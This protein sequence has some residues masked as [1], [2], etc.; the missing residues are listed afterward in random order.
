M[1]LLGFIYMSAPHE[2]RQTRWYRARS[3]RSLGE[4]LQSAR[5]AAG[6]TQDELAA[7]IGSSRP[8]LSRLERGDSPQA[9]TILAILA[10]TGYELVV[11]P[12]GSKITVEPPP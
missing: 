2:S 11:V 3:R 1:N 6:T 7:R 4:A 8:T 12:R 9:D 5:Q 10:A